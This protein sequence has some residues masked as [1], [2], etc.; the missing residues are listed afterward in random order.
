M[1]E[2]RATVRWEKESEG[3]GYKEYNRDH[4]WII[5]KETIAASAAAGYLGTEGMVDP[6]AA[7]VASASACHMLTFLAICSKKR[8][9]VKSYV[10]EAVGQMTAGENKKMWVSL[11]ELDPKIEFE[12]PAAV[13]EATL[14]DIHKVAHR[15]CFIAN[16]LKSEITVKGFALH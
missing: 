10:D 15:E 1:S 5:G 16:S 14:A 7:L 8:I 4:D 2:H 6:E 11:I 13:D 9:V 12:D 3:F